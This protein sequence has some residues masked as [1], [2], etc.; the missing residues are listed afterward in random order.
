MKKVLLASLL[1]FFTTISCFAYETVIIKYPDGEIWDKVYYKRHLN[2]VLLQYVP[3]GQT[4]RNWTR[5]IFIHSYN[6]SNYITN[7]FMANNLA[8]MTQKNPTGEYKY[9]KL[10]DVDSIAGRCTEDFKGIKGQ[11]EIY[12]VTRAHEGIVTVHYINR[13]KEDFFKI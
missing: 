10:T 11:C 4:H 8:K 1:L 7:I 9:M 12:R 13:N 6:D 2:E 5:S 3:R